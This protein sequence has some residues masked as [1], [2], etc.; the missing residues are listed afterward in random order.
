MA[1]LKVGILSDTHSFVDDAVARH[2]GSCDQI[3]HAGDV[4][5]D[6]ALKQLQGI[7]PEVIAVSGNIDTG[8][9]RL[10]CPE[11]R[12]FDAAGAKVLMRHIGGYP[13]R[14]APGV[15]S[16]LQDVHPKIFV[17]GHSHILRVIYDKDIDVLCINP[18]AA[19]RQGWQQVRTLVR[20]NI[21]DGTPHDLQ[22]IELG[23]R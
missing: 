23:R 5:C 18:G 9:V 17:C 13:G 3:W 16:T 4:G 10:R 15:R 8:L 14:Y 2:F 1:T 11:Q 12:I 21:T 19:G 22:V 7:G 6:D 20:L